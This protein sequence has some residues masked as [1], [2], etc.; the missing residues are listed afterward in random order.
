MSLHLGGY[1]HYYDSQKRKDIDLVLTSPTFLKD[2]LNHLGVPVGEIF[3]V[4]VNSE[5]VPLEDAWVKPGDRI[6]VFPPMGG[7]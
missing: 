5:S 4:V 6:E 1:L 2:L 7:G 3:L